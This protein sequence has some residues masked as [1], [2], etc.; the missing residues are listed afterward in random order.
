MRTKR[1]QTLDENNNAIVDRMSIRLDDSTVVSVG[2]IVWLKHDAVH[3]LTTPF[4][5]EHFTGEQLIGQMK[6]S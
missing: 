6:L 5:I 3:F 2:D 1:R 4:I